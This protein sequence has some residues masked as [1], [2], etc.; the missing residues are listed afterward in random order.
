MPRHHHRERIPGSQARAH[1]RAFSRAFAR[2]IDRSRVVYSPRDAERA[3]GSGSCDRRLGALCGPGLPAATT[4]SAVRMTCMPGR[5]CERL[6]RA[7]I[8]VLA[9]PWMVLGAR[10]EEGAAG[11]TAA[12]MA[13]GDHVRW[14]C[15]PA[16]V[17]D[18]QHRHGG[19]LLLRVIRRNDPK[20][21]WE[22]Q[23]SHVQTGG[24]VNHA[25]CDTFTW[26]RSSGGQ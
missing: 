5:T 6:V 10:G 13:C 2:T 4:A 21:S 14:P 7:P 12:W 3:A 11:H 25:G 17:P 22:A 16:A 26:R 19:D 8:A 18:T 9:C 24:V 23:A 1:G 20:S 15:T